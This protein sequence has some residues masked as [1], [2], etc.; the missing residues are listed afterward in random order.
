MS[1]S[2]VF[3]MIDTL[4]IVLFFLSSLVLVFYFFFFFNDPAPPEI[5]PFPLPGPFPTRPQ[6]FAGEARETT[7]GRDD[8]QSRVRRDGARESDEVAARGRWERDDAGQALHVVGSSAVIPD[9]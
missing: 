4:K 5:Y 9:H 7:G 3:V 8:R 1:L 6:S 2:S